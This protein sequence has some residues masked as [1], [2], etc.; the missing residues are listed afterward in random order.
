M[1]VLAAFLVI[2]IGILGF[3]SY[4]QTQ[5]IAALQKR[6]DG[7]VEAK[8]KNGSLE[9]QG[10]CAEQSQRFFKESGY[11][12]KDMAQYE[13]HYNV[14][15]NKCFV[16]LDNTDF[17]TVPGTSFISRNLFDAFEGKSFGEY[18]WKS[19]K[20]KKYWEVKPMMCSVTAERGEKISCDSEDKY[21][22]LIKVYM[23]N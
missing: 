18:I 19:D 21:N 2:T 10:K 16:V 8:P 11:T 23:E 20:V 22:E 13:D 9:L 14:R 5:D 17:K 15:L 3:R 1:K 12:L 4:K 7:F 6:L